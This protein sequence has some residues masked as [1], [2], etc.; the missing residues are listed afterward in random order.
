M[1][2]KKVKVNNPGGLHLRV[3]ARIVQV[4]RQF[5]S[6]VYLSRNSKLAASDSILDIFSLVGKRGDEIALIAEGEDEKEALNNI[7]VL[8]ENGAGI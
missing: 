6:K 7:A 4:A 8:F 5:K 1:E 3:A 2:V